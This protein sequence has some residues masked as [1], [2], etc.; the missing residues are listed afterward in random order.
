MKLINNTLKKTFIQK[1]MKK[2]VISISK[3]S[4]KNKQINLEKNGIIL[5][6]LIFIFIN[7]RMNGHLQWKLK[8]NYNSKTKGD[9][10][11]QITQP[12]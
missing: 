11:L 12:V 10:I 4:L 9:H 6:W 5:F 8:A 2:K 3:Y 1:K 7:Q